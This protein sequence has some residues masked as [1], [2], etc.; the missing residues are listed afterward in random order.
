MSEQQACVGWLRQTFENTR[1]VE[2]LLSSKEL[3]LARVIKN[4]H[5]GACLFSKKSPVNFP[6]T[7]RRFVGFRFAPT[8]ILI[9]GFIDDQRIESGL[10]LVVSRDLTHQA[11]NHFSEVV[12]AL[13]E[14][15]GFIPF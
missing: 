3:S 1:D 10:E 7:G 9:L 6:P 2:S 8:R 11:R 12:V 15:G 5:G 4:S 13:F 14:T